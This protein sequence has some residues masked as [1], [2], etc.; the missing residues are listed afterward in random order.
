MNYSIPA[1][2]TS[3]RI[4]VFIQSDTA[5]GVGKTG[6]AFNTP[7]LTCYAWVDTDDNSNAV[8]IPL[9]TMIRGEWVSGGFVEKDSAHMPGYY[10]FGIPNALLATGIEWLVLYFNGGAG[11]EA[12]EIE[13]EVTAVSNQDGV[14]GGLT[15]LPNANA[16]SAGGLFTQ[17]TGV[18]QIQQESNGQI[19]INVKQWLGITPNALQGGR[20]DSTLGN[21]AAGVITSTSFAAGA[22]DAVWS[23]ASRV[24]TAGTNIVLAKGTG[25]TGLNDVSTGQVNTEVTN[26]L[27]ST[28]IADSI[29]TD[30]SRPSAHQA[31]YMIIQ[32]LTERV[33]SNTTV[34]VKKPDGVTSLFTMAMNDPINPTA[35][36]R[37]S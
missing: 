32:Y 16:E 25:L 35:I 4:P 34:T 7:G 18:G 5:K 9:V 8:Q 6:L 31:L 15:A 27:T 29:P 23:V 3:K 10:D 36:T 2:T 22:L 21:I 37:V 20:V 14:R 33:V 11:V 24:L 17:G 1:G 19:S 12:T 13:I 26:V 30:G 28:V